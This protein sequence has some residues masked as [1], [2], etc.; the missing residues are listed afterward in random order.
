MFA[1]VCTKVENTHHSNNIYILQ[2]NLNAFWNGLHM[3]FVVIQQNR[4]DIGDANE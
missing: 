2:D 1:N 3:N 4:K